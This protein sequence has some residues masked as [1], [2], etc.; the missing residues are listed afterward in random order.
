VFNKGALMVLPGGVNKQS[1]LFA[2]LRD[3]GLSARNVVGI[4]DAE[5]D[6][7]LLEACEC[8]VAVGNAL[9]SLKKRADLVTK[10]THSAGVLEVVD[11]LLEDDLARVEPRLEHHHI[12]LGTHENERHKYVLL[13]P[14]GT[15]LLISG[16]SRAGKSSFVLAL[17]ERIQGAGYQ[18]CLIDPEGDYEA[19]PATVNLGNTHQAP[20]TQD[21]LDVL[22]EPGQNVCVSLLALDGAARPRYFADLQTALGEFQ[23]RSGRP[24]WLIVDEAHHV[25]PSDSVEVQPLAWQLGGL[26]L[27]TLGPQKLSATVRPLVSHVLALGKDPK[28]TLKAAAELL[29]EP[30]PRAQAKDLSKGHGLLWRRGKKRTLPVRLAPASIKRRRHRRKYVE[31]EIPPERSFYFRGPGGSLNLRAQNLQIFMQV[32]EGV[33]DATWEHHL[34]AG[35]YSR[36]IEGE[37]KDRKLARRVAAVERDE[38][39]SAEESRRRV[40]AEVEDRY[41]PPA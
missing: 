2:A 8:A 36:W 34:R 15:G 30:A 1:G 35:D 10:G 14:C 27:V 18:L 13:P 21:V 31:G 4:G 37:L 7:A 22:N 23:A 28:S 33:D 5:N 39:L 9:P 11:A 25:L 20:S 3:L 29:G 26:T 38:S 19:L 16:S 32:A 6:H 24:H 40:R 12:V 41:A 17:V